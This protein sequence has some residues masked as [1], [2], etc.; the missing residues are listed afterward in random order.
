MQPEFIELSRYRLDRA[1]SDLEAARV[2]L[3]S[4]LYLQSLNRS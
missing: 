1:K 2:L 4:G 3:K